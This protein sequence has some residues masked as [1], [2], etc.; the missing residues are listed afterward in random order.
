MKKLT[1]KRG[2]T[3]KYLDYITVIQTIAKSTDSYVVQVTDHEPLPMEESIELADHYNDHFGEEWVA[4][5][6]FFSFDTLE[7]MK[8]FFEI[9][10]R[11]PFYSNIYAISCDKDGNILD[12]NT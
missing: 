5:H 1:Q 3:V 10:N 6:G 2:N 9:F 8:G 7:E 4:Y 11:D 12:I